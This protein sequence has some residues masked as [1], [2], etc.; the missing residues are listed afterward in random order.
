MAHFAME[1]LLRRGTDLS[2][3]GAETSIDADVEAIDRL[4]AVRTVL[5]VLRQATGMRTVLVARVTEESWTACAVLDEG[6]Y[7]LNA[8]DRL[9]LATTF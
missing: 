4:D 8:G 2:I 9:D 3:G 7:G 6:G 1:S 5:K